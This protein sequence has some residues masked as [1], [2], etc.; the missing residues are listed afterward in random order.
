MKKLYTLLL[1]LIAIT[2]VGMFTSCDDGWVPG[3]GPGPGN[4]FYDGALNGFWELYQVNGSIVAP[5]RINYL[6]FNGNGRGWY[7]YY[8]NGAPLEERISYWCQYSGNSTSDYQINI[9][10]ENGSA[11]TMAYWFTHN[12]NYLWMQW[13]AYNQGTTTY[14]YR[15]VSGFP[16][17]PA[18][19][20]SL[21]LSDSFKAPGIEASVDGLHN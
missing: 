1:S 11:A 10:Y 4:D 9:R 17:K 3:P 12:G 15:S 14:V 7:Y 8:R 16:R 13:Y 6:E 18:A 21:K 2:S 5:D 19:E 20:G